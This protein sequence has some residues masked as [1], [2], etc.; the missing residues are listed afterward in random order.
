MKFGHKMYYGAEL[1][2]YI[3][4]ANWSQELTKDL[5]KNIIR[6]IKT[7]DILNCH[8]PI[9]TCLLISE[10]LIQI[11]S[12]SIQHSSRC[13]KVV[14]ELMQFCTN[15][16]ESNP[17]EN[18]I[19]FLM[20]QKDSK[21]RNSLQIASDNS[22]YKVLE[23][24]EVGT[25]VK[26]LWNGAVSTNDFFGASSMHRYL[27]SE[28][29][30]MDPFFC[31]DSL[32]KTKSY[33]Y[34]YYVWTESPS[35]RYIPE[36]IST[37]TLIAIYNVYI[38]FLV[39]N[40]HILNNVNQ[41]D[42]LTIYLLYIYIAWAVCISLNALTLVIY[43]VWTKRKMRV[44]IWFWAEVYIFIFAL[45]LLIDV[46]VIFNGT[47][48]KTINYLSNTLTDLALT[49]FKSLGFQADLT[50]RND[51]IVRVILLGIND[52]LVWMRL[53]G[54]LLT[55]KDVGPLMRMIYLMVIIL[56]KQ[57]IIC[58]LYLVCWGAIFTAIFNKNNP[59]FKDFSTTV[60]TLFGGF[61]NNFDTNGFKTY[62]TFGALIMTFY[63]CIS[64]ILLINLLIALLS[65]V[66]ETL[67]KVVD[68]S[69]R[70][71]LIN[72]Y[73]K[74]KWDDNFGY[75][76]YLCTPLN[77][78][79]LAVMAYSFVFN[80][81]KND[82]N[83]L[84]D[85]RSLND[86]VCKLYHLIFYFPYI[87][88][89]Y[90]LYCL[91]LIP[92]C[93]FKGIALMSKHQHNLK[94]GRIFK[95]INVFKWIFG[96]IIFLL[97]IYFRDIY[98]LIATVF[99]RI[100]SSSAETK[101]IKKYISPDE[102]K[103]FLTFIHSLPDY[104]M[105]LHELFL[106]YLKF[107]Q[108]SLSAKDAK[109]KEKAEYISKLNSAA[110]LLK[111]TKSFAG[112]NSVILF[113]KTGENKNING[114]VT[115]SSNFIKKNLI[116]IE[117]LENF[118]IEDGSSNHT[119]D[120]EKLKMLLPKIISIDNDYIKRLVYT[121]VSSLNKA[122]NKLKAKKNVFLQYQLLNKIVSQAIRIDKEIDSEI[123]K[124]LRLAQS[125]ID[126]DIYNN[127]NTRNN[128]STN[129]IINN[130]SNKSNK[131][132]DENGTAGNLTA[133]LKVTNNF[134]DEIRHLLNIKKNDLETKDKIKKK[135]TIL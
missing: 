130:I 48:N 113:T 129:N 53:T 125:Q 30:T 76:I 92:I 74:Y 114:D 61:V 91:I 32:D 135:K 107:E 65:N 124:I 117:I 115:F 25:I 120:I 133:L 22:Y 37:L 126:K 68:A 108:S 116:I 118:L 43:T 4:K 99:V 110:N 47:T 127:L 100:Q 17:D 24:P 56:I 85:Y 93:Y 10:F 112:R 59:Q 84:S 88:I 58:G 13:E 21:D 111:G 134:K 42:S 98:L 39:V 19:K 46:K 75:L 122:V 67:S 97:V 90:I 66:Y 27:D 45:L 29:K 26:K 33:Y 94:V 51:F 89:V 81:K 71:V 20:T 69:H 7:K 52:V 2:N 109:L 80:R 5:C 106:E 50:L 62:E 78:I 44:D 8:S 16:Q 34:Q 73:R 41:L 28:S 1:L 54:I 64:A 31:F 119:I 9:L 128:S 96:G 77:I 86:F 35:L 102:V 79:N 131:E 3:Y 132:Y 121:D 95:I 36:S 18:Y 40:N 87:L 72:Y 70:S 55:F 12:Q 60:V 38:Y 57:L 104:A 6:T 103:I 23:T 49:T 123:S 15:I 82:K 14:N 105:D 63:I 101:R 83:S 11:G